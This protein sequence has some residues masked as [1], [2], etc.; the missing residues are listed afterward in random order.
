MLGS[1]SHTR[2][3]S[4]TGMNLLLSYPPGT[5]GAQLCSLG[6]QIKALV[7]VRNTSEESSASASVLGKRSCSSWL[8][9]RTLLL[10]FYADLR[11]SLR[12]IHHMKDLNVDIMQITKSI[13]VEIN[14]DDL[15]IL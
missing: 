13:N 3:R 7:L 14:S 11:P 12:L 2:T 5:L 15:S 4:I 8:S 1:S 6:A 9:W 10:N